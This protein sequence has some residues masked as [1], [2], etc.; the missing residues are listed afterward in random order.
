MNNAER[1]IKEKVMP[2]S[3]KEDRR[4]LS[5]PNAEKAK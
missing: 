1:A 2:D 5:N 3:K 4:D